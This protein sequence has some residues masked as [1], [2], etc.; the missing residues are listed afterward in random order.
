MKLALYSQLID[1]LSVRDVYPFW[2]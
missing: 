2:W 1:A